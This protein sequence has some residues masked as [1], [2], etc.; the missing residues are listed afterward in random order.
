MIHLSESDTKKEK[1]NT[2]KYIFQG[3]QAKSR[4]WFNLDHEWLKENLRTHE[5]DFYRKYI[6]LNLGVM[7]QKNIKYVE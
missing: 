2:K 3:H 6:K 7:I 1:E 4:R 5:P